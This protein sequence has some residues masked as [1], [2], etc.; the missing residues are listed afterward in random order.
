MADKPKTVRGTVGGATVET[1]QENAERLGSAFT[2]EKAPAKKAA[3][4]SSAKSDE[5]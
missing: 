3:A 2:P 5:K 1:S 4:K